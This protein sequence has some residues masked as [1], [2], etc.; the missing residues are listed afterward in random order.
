[1]S[2]LEAVGTEVSLVPTG[3]R[4]IESF[5]EHQTR[6]CA[7]PPPLRLPYIGVLGGLVQLF[8]SFEGGFGWLFFCFCCWVWVCWVFGVVTGLVGG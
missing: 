4:F 7:P 6:R 8:W 3:W 1:M 5:I 2:R